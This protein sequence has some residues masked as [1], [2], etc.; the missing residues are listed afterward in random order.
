MSKT[1]VLGLSGGVDSSVAAVLL[2]EQ[3]YNVIGLFM[4][5]WDSTTNNDVLGNP[6]INDE[7]CPQEIDYQDAVNVAKKIGIPIFKVD[8]IKEYWDNVFTYFLDEY[9]KGRTPNP[10]I[11]C[12]K[13]IK[14]DAFLEY[15]KK[16]KADYIAMGHYAKVVVIKNKVTL[17]R[18]EDNNKDQT[19]FLSQL[20]ESQLEKT[21]FP[22]G[23]LT[24]KE[25]REIAHK[26]DLPTK[27]KKDS[28]G[29]CFIG[30]RD[31]DKFLSNYLPSKKGNMVTENGVK[32][33]EHNGLMYYTIGQRKGLGIGGSNKYGNDP[34]FV[35]GKDLEK[36][37][38]II[39]QGFH[40]PTLYSDSCLVEDVNLINHDT[41]DNETVYSAKFRYRQADTK[42][43]IK[44]IGKNLLITF[45]EDV[46]AVTPGQAAVIYQEERCLGGGFIKE[47]YKNNVKRK[48]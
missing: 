18:G 39:G 41:F 4:R 15:A 21:L 14:F 2:K 5:N 47:V 7:I 8:F 16:F 29:I 17:L 13:Y 23:H 9:K 20:S 43:T 48:Y 12:N 3:G 27:D 22:I 45:L 26:Y 33:S 35:I 37:E 10:D 32:I 40:H 46:R 19:Y 28:T 30:E 6:D 44:H 31:F 25:V 11:L 24:K 34:W 1:V 42:V 38:L 36:N